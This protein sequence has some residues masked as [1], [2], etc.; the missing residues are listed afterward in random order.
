MVSNSRPY[1]R[2]FKAAVAEWSKYRIVAGL[3]TSSSPVVLKTRRVGQRCILN[4]SRAQTS[5][6]WFGV[7]KLGGCG[8][9]VVKVSDH[10]RHVRSLIPVPL[11]THRVGERFTLNLSRAETSSRCENFIPLHSVKARNRIINFNQLQGPNE[12]EVYTDGSKIGT[13]TGLDV[14]VVVSEGSVC[15][16]NPFRVSSVPLDIVAAAAEW[17]RYRIVTC[18]VTISSPVPLK[19]RRQLSHWTTVGVMISLNI[20]D[21]VVRLSSRHSIYFQWIHS[22]IGLN[23]NAIVGSLAKSA[24]AEALRGDASLI[25]AEI[26]SIK[27]MEL[28]AL[29]RVPPA[30]LWYFGRTPRW[31]H[32][33]NI[34]RDQ[35]TALSRFLVATSSL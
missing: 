33:L 13:E 31:C 29:W 7:E 27:R 30:H 14:G 32:E 18:L 5:S 10:G 24:T 34:P 12:W 21:L 23:G 20:L 8:S 11:K 22:H 19:T 25:F 16:S 9:T 17:Y 2:G 1:C 26:S 3:V 6:R 4:L 28:N 15:S 35:Q